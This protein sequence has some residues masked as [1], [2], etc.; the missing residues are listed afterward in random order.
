MTAP[1]T[2]FAGGRLGWGVSELARR[3]LLLLAVVLAGASVA[4]AAPVEVTAELDQDIVGLDQN[5]TLS[6][7]VTVHGD[8]S[9]EQIELPSSPKLRELGTSTS[10]SSSFS[11]GQGGMSVTRSTTYRTTF[12]PLRE[13]DVMLP[14]ATVIVSGQTWRGPPLCLKIVAAG[15][16]PSPQTAAR[17]RQSPFSGFGIA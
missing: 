2:G 12:Q 4:R 8:G 6:V 16:G 10:Q 15:Q 5:V 11:L 3:G 14:P 9:V 1:S 13:G 7:T 17:P